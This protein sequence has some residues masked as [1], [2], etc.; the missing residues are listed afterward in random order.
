MLPVLNLVPIGATLAERFLYLPS[1]L[2]CLAVGA[3]VEARGRAEARSGRGL[4]ASVVATAAALAVLIPL[5]RR[6]VRVFRDDLTLWAHAAAVRPD[7]AHVRYN[8]GYFLDAA[9]R[10]TPEDVH[11]PDA[12]SELAASLR[13]APRHLYAGL[14][15]HLLGQIALERRGARPPDAVRAAGHFREAIA[16]QPG[17]ADSRIQ[18]ASLAVSVPGLVSP[19]EGWAVLQPLREAAGLEPEQQQAVSALSAEL[20]RQLDASGSSAPMT[21]TSSPDGS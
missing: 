15:H 11:L 18:L 12:A 9:G 14:A 19:E 5:C 21:G 16:L 1:V 20:A 4:G 7:V 2:L 8:H 10:Q 17:H 3:L 6:D 13:I